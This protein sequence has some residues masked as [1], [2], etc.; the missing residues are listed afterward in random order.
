MLTNRDVE[1]I[2]SWS[3]DF[4][5]SFAASLSLE[6]SAL[7]YASEIAKEFLLAACQRD[8]VTPDE[9]TQEGVP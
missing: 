5:G 9:I 2:E 7:E 8:Q 4:A 6:G 3:G 1:H